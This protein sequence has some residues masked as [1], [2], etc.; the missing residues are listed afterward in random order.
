MNNFNTQINLLKQTKDMELICENKD[1][2]NEVIDQAAKVQLQAN[3]YFSLLKKKYQKT[4]N[5]EFDMA[6]LKERID[7]CVNEFML[8]KGYI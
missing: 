3:I 5:F 8:E 6:E 7:K 1:S 2:I 4:D